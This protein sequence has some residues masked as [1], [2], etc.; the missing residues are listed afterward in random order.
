MNNKLLSFVL[1]AGLAMVTS[2]AH[3]HTKSEYFA[4][5][6]DIVSQN[7]ALKTTL[8]EMGYSEIEAAA[9][10]TEA[11]EAAKNAKLDLK[12]GTL[13]IC[14]KARIGAILGVRR[15]ICTTLFN[16]YSVAFDSL[17]L[18]GQAMAG[19]EAIYFRSANRD[20]HEYCYLGVSLSSG[21][22]V[23]LDAG[24][25]IE[26]SCNGKKDTMG[27]DRGFFV[28]VSVGAGAGADYSA[29]AVTVKHLK[30]YWDLEF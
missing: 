14:G 9:R 29:D 26:T 28:Q 24:A 23:S 2:A 3:A 4:K 1:A 10:F 8:A 17:V 20:A 11:Q 30:N 27:W 18:G 6:L 15:S 12:L 16:S 22:I 21:Y 5:T 13:A 7:T 25:M 19:V